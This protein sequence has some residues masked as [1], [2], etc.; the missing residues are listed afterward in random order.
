MEIDMPK[1]PIQIP[2]ED[3]IDPSLPGWEDPEETPPGVDDPSPPEIE[4]HDVPVP[5]PIDPIPPDPTM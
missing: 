5:S 3:P 1:E 4:P 2:A